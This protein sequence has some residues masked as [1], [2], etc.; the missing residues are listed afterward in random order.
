MKY[1]IWN[2]SVIVFEVDALFSHVSSDGRTDGGTEKLSHRGAPL[3][4]ILRSTT[5]AQV[6]HSDT[7]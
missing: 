5:L 7:L 4:K 6:C 2:T 3:L 1:K